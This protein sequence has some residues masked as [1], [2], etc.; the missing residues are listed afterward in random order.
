MNVLMPQ[1]QRG[2]LDIVVGR[3]DQ[4]LP[5]PHLRT[6][7]LY[8]EPINFVAR[9]GHPLFER[10]ALDWDDVLGCSW[11]VWPPGT[12]VRNAFETALA[13]AGHA[14]PG[15]CV[16]SNSSILNLT[17]L[18]NTDLI[19]VA[20]HRAALRFEQLNAVRILP[21][22]LDGFGSVSMYWHPDSASRQAVALAIESLR[23]SAEPGLSG[24]A[25]EGG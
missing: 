13:A 2:E 9:P 19:G 12:P 16:E 18:N 10:G 20:S 3:T 22:R 6:E 21:M 23:L 7:K 1:L 14:L 5:D 8:M 15:H 4:A 25:A 17:L 24:W 11:I